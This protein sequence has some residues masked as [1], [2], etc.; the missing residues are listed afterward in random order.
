MST[1]A[2]ASRASNP[3]SRP[4]T[5]IRPS[6]R[7]SLRSPH[8]PAG[9]S[10]AS[11]LAALEPAFAEF[12]DSMAD[13]E[14]NMMHVQLLHESL[15]R[16]G[17]NFASFLYGLNMNAFCVDFGEGPGEESWRRAREREGAVEGAEK[18][19][20]KP[21]GGGTGA[22]T[23]DAEGTFM[24]GVFYEVPLW[25][26]G[27]AD[28]ETGLQILRLWRIHLSRRGRDLGLQRRRR[29][30]Q[31]PKNGKLQARADRPALREEQHPH[32]DLP[33]VHRA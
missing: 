22:G 19:P 20:M 14:A 17:E 15:A 16:F 23:F 11:P 13:L 12:A 9:S 27:H 7:T 1:N 3:P 2:R 6:S 32:G 10:D 21:L 26:T 29:Q 8:P 33:G 31:L 30:R 28:R 25:E 4:T 18:S 24:Y 5:P